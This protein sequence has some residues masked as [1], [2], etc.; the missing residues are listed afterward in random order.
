MPVE[1]QRNDEEMEGI[2]RSTSRKY[3]SVSLVH[4]GCAPHLF[5]DM[6][7]SAGQ[8]LSR[9]EF[10]KGTGAV[11]GMVALG[12]FASS[13]MAAT[14]AF[15]PG[16]KAD[17]IYHGGP[18]LT[19]VKDGDRAEALAILDGRIL[20]VGGLDE[21]MTTKGAETKLIHLGGKTLM[22]GFHDAHSHL[23]IQSVK[24][25]TAN[26][27][28]KPIGEAGSIADIQRI[29]REWIETKKIEPGKWVIGW[30]YDDTGIAEKR[31]PN[32]DDLDAVSTEH[33][34]VL[35]HISSHLIP[36]TAKCWRKSGSQWKPRPPTRA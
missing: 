21:V 16:A 6:I 8:E 18:I 30:G 12:G 34:I 19:M 25:S 28:P 14:Q 7:E 9:R 4:H 2:P 27:D 11:C 26:L 29:L 3:D 17:A 23:V 31:H 36:A 24:F 1:S 5:T 32:H 33:P 10:I 22:P 15:A 20:A 35:V 13:V